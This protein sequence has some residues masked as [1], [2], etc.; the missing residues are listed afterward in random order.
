MTYNEL[1][2]MLIEFTEEQLKQTVTIY[3]SGDGEFYSLVHDYP[4]VE[5]DETCDVLDPGH[6]YLVI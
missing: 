1:K 4:L 3:V 6:K 2:H 5:S